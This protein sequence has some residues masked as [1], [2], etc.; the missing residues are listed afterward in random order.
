VGVLNS[1]NS[2]KGWLRAEQFGA[3]KSN[4]SAVETR[5]GG[6]LY[7][8]KTVGWVSL[9]GARRALARAEHGMAIRATTPTYTP[10]PGLHAYINFVVPSL[11]L[12]SSFYCLGLG[13]SVARA[14]APADRQNRAACATAICS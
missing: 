7:K 12:I 10:Q 1:T 8:V 5:L 9:A 13:L 6:C 3:R 4:G 11:G 2:G 14:A